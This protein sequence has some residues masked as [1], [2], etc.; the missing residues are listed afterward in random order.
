[1]V[2]RIRTRVHDARI[3][4]NWGAVHRT[5][6]GLAYTV[7]KR[8]T[9]V[10]SIAAFRVLTLTFLAVHIAAISEMGPVREDR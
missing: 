5:V 3:S 10:W 2:L 1:M 9:F 4:R 6:D 7:T 8:A